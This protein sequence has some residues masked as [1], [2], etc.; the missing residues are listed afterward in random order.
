MSMV[1]TVLSMF[2]LAGIM[3]VIV[4]LFHASLRYQVRVES[5][6]KM[7]MLATRTMNDVRAFAQNPANFNGGLSFYNGRTWTDPDLP[8]FTIRT[9]TVTTGRSIYSPCETLEVPWTTTGQARQMIRSVI[10]VRVRVSRQSDAVSLVGYIAE[11]VREPNLNLVISP[12]TVPPVNGGATFS[13]SVTAYD[14]SGLPIQDLFYDWDIDAGTGNATI[15]GSSPR[16][17]RT[18]TII[19]SYD[20]APAPGTISVDVQ[21]RYKGQLLKGSIGPIDMLP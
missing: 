1:E 15:Q 11:P 13:L 2:L 10:P 8:D 17:G 7:A 14:T 6:G 21:C 12:L 19:N 16:D 18:V 20:G 5:R 9:D 3:L 4:N